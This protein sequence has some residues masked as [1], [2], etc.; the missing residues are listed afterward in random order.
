MWLYSGQVT[1]LW[2]FFFAVGVSW[3]ASAHYVGP[4]KCAVC[5]REIAA[6]QAKTPMAETWQ[7]VSTTWLPQIF[8]TQVGEPPNPQLGYSLARHG[9]QFSWA[10][11]TPGTSQNTLPIEIVMGGRRHGL[12]FLARIERVDDMP[13][14]RAALIQSR[15]EWSFTQN[16]L[17]LAPGC[18]AARPTTLETAFGL[19]LSPTFEKRCLVCHGR[20]DTLGAGKLGGVRCE[21][22]HGP[23]SEH[24]KAPTPATIVNPRR[25]TNE[26]SIAVCAQCHVGLTN[27]SDPTP[28]DLL[29]AN[30][31]R[32][33]T[34]SECFI[35]SGKAFSCAACHN[36]HDSSQ[37]SARSV[38]TCRGCHS[39]AVK[40]HAAICPVNANSNCITCHMPSV[41]LGPLH[42]VDHLIRVHPEQNTSIPAET[43]LEKSARRSQIRPLREYLKVIVSKTQSDSEKASRRLAK[44]EDFYE[45]AR[46]LSGDPSAPIGGYLGPQW[47]SQMDKAV[48]EAAAKLDYGETGQ[49][50]NSAGKIVILKRLARNFKWQ[51]SQ[52][53]RPEQALKIYPH[54]LRALNSI[55]AA[56]AENGNAQRASEILRLANR[57]YPNDAALLVEFGMTLSAL[58]RHAEEITAYRK[59]L[60]L[61]PDFL[62]SYSKLGMALF[63]SGNI[64]EAVATFRQGLNINPLSADL[65]ADLSSALAKQGDADG[66]RK[67][68]ALAERI[69]AGP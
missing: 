48:A 14:K 9:N 20:P 69:A 42:L 62:A 24:V 68:K 45:V 4:E 2:L 23:G 56:F 59:A 21:S 8:T 10:A 16:N 27:F 34:S 5:H 18:T 28:Q 32:A 35:Q 37:D 52:M 50:T 25:L 12:G 13:L 7:G 41:E 17:V 22:C 6:A 64:N 43:D 15:Y 60:E 49:A 29:V 51:A 54:S 53:E 55:A 38:A 3:G 46:E 58:G 40:P 61:E 30:Q 1:R 66:A 11:G 39:A 65:Y 67:A 63:S 26:E 19:V 44:G 33:V 57:F 31:V 36:P 47:L